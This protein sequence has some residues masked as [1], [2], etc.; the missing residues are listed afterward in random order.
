MT[1]P[2]ES[3][4]RTLVIA[5]AVALVCSALVSTAVYVLRPIQS[6]YALLER[7]RA[8][9]SVGYGSSDLSDAAVVQSFLDLDAR[10]LDLDTGQF[11]AAID[12]HS[13]DHWREQLADEPQANQPAAEPRLVPVYVVEVN[14]VRSRVVLPV[15]GR[16]MWSTIYGYI[17]LGPDLNTVAG[18][19]F[20]LHGETP[21]IGDRIQ[22]PVWLKSWQGKRIYDTADAVQIRVGRPEAL[23]DIHQVDLISGASVTS[24]AV[25]QFVNSWFGERGYGP[26]LA[27]LRREAD[28]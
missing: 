26:W 13:F 22:N 2:G 11:V 15:H 24:E 18:V 28:G 7:N 25:G 27:R 12:G 14:G 16:G 10:V 17:A 9:V 23:A 20:H 5:V 4:A 21:G 1:V 6:A 8:I 19:N 3:V